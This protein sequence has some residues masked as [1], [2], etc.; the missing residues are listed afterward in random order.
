MEALALQMQGMVSGF[1]GS[2]SASPVFAMRTRESAPDPGWLCMM[3]AGSIREACSRVLEGIDVD[4]NTR[5]GSCVRMA[6]A[7]LLAVS[8]VA[9]AQPFRDSEGNGH[10]ESGSRKQV[11]GFSAMLLVTPDLDWAEKWN[12]PPD[13]IPHFREAT[14]VERGGVVAILVFFSNPLLVDG[15][16]DTAVNLRMTE[17]DGNMQLDAPDSPCYTG[18]YAG[19]PTNVLLCETSL[20]YRADPDDLSGEWIVDVVVK[21]RHRNVEIPLRTSFRV[22]D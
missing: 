3:R 8:G 13:V 10:P 7:L 4:G 20:G 17:P 12:T 19:V 1:S 6:A 14:E 15:H 18:P 11:D 22:L 2:W 9:G 21:D 5:W 16:M